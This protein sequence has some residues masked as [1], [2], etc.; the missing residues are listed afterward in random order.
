MI[1]LGIWIHLSSVEQVLTFEL[2]LVMAETK[3][4][5]YACNMQLHAHGSAYQAM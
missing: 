5:V 4:C 3:A 2:L 1:W